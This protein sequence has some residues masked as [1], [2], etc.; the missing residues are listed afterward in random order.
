MRRTPLLCCLLLVPLVATAEPA[1]RWASL[2]D[3]GGAYDDTGL[4]LAPHPSGD[5]VVA[6]VSFDG[7]DGSDVLVERLDAADGGVVW[8]QRFPAFD[9]NDMMVAGLAWD[10]DGDLIVGGS[11]LGCVG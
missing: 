2:A 8:S 9:G 11:V 4:L 1:L 5:V 6:G 7:V 3:G 10:P